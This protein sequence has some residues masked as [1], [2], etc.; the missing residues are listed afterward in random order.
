MPKVYLTSEERKQ[1]VIE[2]R[3]KS[4]KGLIQHK[5]TEYGV[6]KETLAKT[7]C[8]GERALYYR[9]QSPAERLNVNEFAA[10][11]GVLRISNDEIIDVLRKGA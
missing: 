5:I 7:L 2:R 10:L 9:L 4:L 3:A 8:V 11:M 1:S 6:S